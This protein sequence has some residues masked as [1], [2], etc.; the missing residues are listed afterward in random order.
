MSF[1]KNLGDIKVLPCHETHKQSLNLIDFLVSM[2]RICNDN[3][4]P[5][6]EH[7]TLEDTIKLDKIY[8]RNISLEEGLHFPDRVA[9]R[10]KVWIVTNTDRRMN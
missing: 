8:G 1:G 9:P 10:I 3:F 5:N 6:Y 2:N 4:D 7:I